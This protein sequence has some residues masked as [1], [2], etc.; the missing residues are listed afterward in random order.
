MVDFLFVLIE[1]CS[2]GIRAETLRINID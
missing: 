2:L 1:L